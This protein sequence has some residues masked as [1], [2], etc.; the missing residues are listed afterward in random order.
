V[1]L[2]VAIALIVLGQTIEENMKITVSQRIES[3]WEH[4]GT[5]S[6]KMSGGDFYFEE[7]PES[8]SVMVTLVH[9]FLQTT[10][11]D[12]D[13]AADIIVVMEMLVFPQMDSM[14]DDPNCEIRVNDTFK[15]AVRDITS[16]MIYTKQLVFKLD[17]DNVQ[18]PD[19]F[20]VLGTDDD[21]EDED[22]D[23]NKVSLYF[24]NE[25]SAVEAI[26]EA[27]ASIGDDA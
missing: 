18:I 22:E 9:V 20:D 26:K 3:Y 25:E 4:I 27:I 1:H 6:V 10:V 16:H 8:E 11:N 5:S 23:E 17:P 21:E 13:V 15:S 14:E 19:D 24:I 7:D 2:Y 12:P